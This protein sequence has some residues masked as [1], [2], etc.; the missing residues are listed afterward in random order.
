MKGKQTIIDIVVVLVIPLAIVAGF[1][2]WKTDNTPSLLLS[3]VAPDSAAKPGEELGAKTKAALATLRSIN[4]DVSLFDDPVYQS[5]KDFP[6]T[7]A[8]T[9]LGRPYPFTLPDVLRKQLS[10]GH[11]STNSTIGTGADVAQKLDGLKQS[12]K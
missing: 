8:T 6:S 10:K 7:I 1:Y 3:F 4:F 12:V 11:S 9:T 5:L 2:F